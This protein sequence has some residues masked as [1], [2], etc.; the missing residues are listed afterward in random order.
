MNDVHGVHVL[1]IDVVVIYYWRGR[2]I[3]QRKQR[4]SDYTTTAR[5]IY[6]RHHHHP[7]RG[8]SLSACHSS[9]PAVLY[10]L[11]IYTTT[12]DA[13]HPAPSSYYCYCWRLM[14]ALHERPIRLVFIRH[15]SFLGALTCFD[16][17]VHAARCW[18][19]WSVTINDDVWSSFN[20]SSY[21][22]FKYGGPTW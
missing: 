8:A 6:Y 20:R 18:R 5:G 19:V 3:K 17:L 1:Y 11:C 10:I 21:I 9:L 13:T 16:D 7:G 12:D 2:A 4:P 14:L 22:A 15:Q